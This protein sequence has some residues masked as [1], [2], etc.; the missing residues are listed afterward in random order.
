MLSQSLLGRGP[1]GNA[2]LGISSGEG[3]LRLT[4]GVVRLPI[5]RL[6]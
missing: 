1:R 5:F 4:L 6:P 3:T 2:S